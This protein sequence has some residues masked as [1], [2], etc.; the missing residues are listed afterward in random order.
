MCLPVFHTF[1]APISLV[2]PLRLGITTYFLPRFDQAQFVDAV[3]AFDITETAIVPPILAKLVQLPPDDD[4][5]RSLRYVLCAGAPISAELQSELYPFIHSE[6]TVAQVWGATELGWVSMF[7]P[8]EKDGT[9]S[10]GNLLPGLELK[11]VNW[12]DECVNEENVHGEAMIRSSSTFFGYLD[13]AGASQ[14]A[15]DDDGFYHTGDRIYVKDNKL[16][17]DGR[18]KEIMKVNGWQVSPSEIE[19]VLI[20][21]PDVADVAVAGITWIDAQG[22]EVTRPRAYI[23]KKRRSFSRNGQHLEKDLQDYVASRLMSYK[24][25]TGG[26]VFVDAIPRNATGKILRRLLVASQVNTNAN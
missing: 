12:R 15:F 24:R 8:G 26:V 17:I 1:A 2:E 5:L 21:H 23:V 4:R 6:A 7:A 10:V 3:N 18:I 13:H 11:I 14:A 22:L 20:Q 25:L 19:K 16:Y 9:G